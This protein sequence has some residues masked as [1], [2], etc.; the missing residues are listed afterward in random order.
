MRRPETPSRST[1]IAAAATTL[2]ALVAMAAAGPRYAGACSSRAAS[3]EVA[4]TLRDADAVR[5]MA[6]VVAAAARDLLATAHA[7]AALPA[8]PAPA[9]PPAAGSRVRFPDAAR[10]GGDLPRLAER[11]LDIPPPAA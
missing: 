6:A 8:A 5:V 11:L 4:V 7:Q 1:S 10:G 2:M 3:A 9:A